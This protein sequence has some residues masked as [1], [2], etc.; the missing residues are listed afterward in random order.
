MQ[1]EREHQVV[2]ESYWGARLQSLQNPLGKRR[3]LVAAFQIIEG[4]AAESARPVR[5]IELGCGEGHILGELLK[6]CETSKLAVGDCAGVDNQERVIERARRLYPRVSFSVADYAERPLNLQPFDLVMMVGT[7]HEVYS[8]SRP[9]ASSEIE[10]G[11]GKKAVAK[12]LGHGTRLV[13]DDR[14]LVLFDGVEHPLP[15][16]RIVV[17]FNSARALD[18]FKKIVSEYEAIRLSYE[19]SGGMGRVRI[20]M[21]DFTRYITKTR[22]FNS[23]LWE[24]EK[25][26]SYQYF[27]EEEFKKC[28]G[29]FGIDVLKLQC[30]SPRQKDWDDRVTIKTPGVAFPQENIL[31]VGRKTGKAS[32]ERA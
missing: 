14:Y 8:G 3:A 5:I 20:S 11:L 31:I 2:W 10:P 12:A 25:R 24:I 17:G 7:L 18:E 32:A 29:E 19:E 30:S 4:L 22:F 9:V 28:L 6:M 23:G 21:R 1:E 15:D 27:T 13:G 26:E 16:L